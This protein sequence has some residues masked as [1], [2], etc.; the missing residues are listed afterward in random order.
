MAMA[1]LRQIRKKVTRTRRAFR[2]ALA[3]HNK[4]LQTYVE[5]RNAKG[6]SALPPK[7]NS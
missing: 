5:A 3:A 1:S 4:A 6:M 7:F 2:A